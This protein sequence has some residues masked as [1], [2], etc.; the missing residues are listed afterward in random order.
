MSQKII[1]PLE[2]SEYLKQLMSTVRGLINHCKICREGAGEMAQRLRT[3]AALPQDPGSIPFPQRA[4]H[5]CFCNSS[6][7]ASDTLTGRQAGHQCT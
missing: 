3:Q 1:I 5:T 4:A 6:S 2:I 7:G